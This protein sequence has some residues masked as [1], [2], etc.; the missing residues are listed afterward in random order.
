MHRA[1]GDI[2]MERTRIAK[3]G[4]AHFVPIVARNHRILEGSWYSYVP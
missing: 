3:H 2:A 4:S 1:R